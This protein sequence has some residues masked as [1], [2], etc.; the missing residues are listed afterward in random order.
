MIAG[1]Y[2]EINILCSLILLIIFIKIQADVYMKHL[3][4]FMS[5]SIILFILFFLSDALW[6]LI[7]S[8]MIDVGIGVNYLVNVMYFVLSGVSAYFCF[9]YSYGI[10]NKSISINNVLYGVLSIP[11][12]ILTVMAIYSPVNKWIFYLDEAGKY[13]RGSLYVIQI[14]VTFGYLA[15][16]AAISIYNGMNKDNIGRK[17]LYFSF[18]SFLLFPTLAAI[19]Q[20]FIPGYPTVPVGMTL[21]VIVTYLKVYDSM[22]LMDPLTLIHNRNWLYS[23][24]ETYS[25]E[26]YPSEYDSIYLLLIDIDSLAAINEKYTTEYGDK[27][28]KLLSLTLM[29]ISRKTSINGYFQPC[30]YGDDEFILVSEVNDGKIMEDVLRYINE[31]LQRVSALHSLP[32]TIEISTGCSL[33]DPKIDYIQDAI[34]A[35]DEDM[36]KM[37]KLKRNQFM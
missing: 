33:Y 3:H 29:N 23:W 37:K 10:L 24:N 11:A 36:Y 13:H 30:R 6:A 28:L 8:G 25:N 9:I 32:F 22:I 14:L 1:L 35:A 12:I 20:I 2:I 31:E 34:K 4:R 18:A 21:A 7:D 17:G 27:A 5:Y 19:V 16:T 15:V 26:D